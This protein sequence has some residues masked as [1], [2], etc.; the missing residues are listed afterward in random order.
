[1]AV[2]SNSR[3]ALVV[4]KVGGSLVGDAPVESEQARTNVS[5]VK[6]KIGIPHPFEWCNMVPSFSSM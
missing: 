6:R 4:S 2:A 5:V 3:A 1:M